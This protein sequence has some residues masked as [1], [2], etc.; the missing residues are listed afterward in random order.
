MHI[1]K[2][3]KSTCKVSKGSDKNCGRSKGDKIPTKNS[4]PRTTHHAKPKT[5]SLPFFF[6]NAGDKKIRILS[7]NFHFLVVKFS[8]YL[9]RHVFVMSGTDTIRSTSSSQYQKGRQP[10][11]INRPKKEQV[12]SRIRNPS[13][14]S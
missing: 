10:N 3:S 5:V 13:P 6:E 11:T 1:F 9:N 7:E 2:P 8:I 12:A 4:K 14:K